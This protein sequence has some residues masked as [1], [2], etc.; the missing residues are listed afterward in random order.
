VGHVAHMGEMRNAHKIMVGRSE[1]RRPLRRC[2]HSLEDNMK[3]D[4]RKIG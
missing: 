1:G 4:L 3:M 2:M